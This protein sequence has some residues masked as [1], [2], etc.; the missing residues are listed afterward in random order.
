MP[1]GVHTHSLRNGYISVLKKR[2][3]AGLR[4]RLP[5]PVSSPGSTQGWHQ[6][7]AFVFEWDLLDFYGRETLLYVYNT[8]PRYHI[9]RSIPGLRNR[10]RELPYVVWRWYLP[11][12]G[13]AKTWWAS[14]SGG[15][16]PLVRRHRSASSV[17]VVS[18]PA[19]GEVDACRGAND[20]Q[21]E[22]CHYPEA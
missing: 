18:T 19:P 22:P 3:G 8:G 16:Q 17:P 12:S 5:C 15:S 6:H 10:G 13:P 2:M 9:K 14:P 4:F 1:A 11:D 21:E 20:A 7:S